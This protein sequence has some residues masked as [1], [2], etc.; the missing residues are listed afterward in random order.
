MN[1]LPCT[2]M[3][4]DLPT[5]LSSN[6]LAFLEP[7]EEVWPGKSGRK[8][9]LLECHSQ[10]QDS[11]APYDGICGFSAGMDSFPG[12]LFR[13]PLRNVPSKLSDNCYTIEN[14]RVLTSALKSDAKFLL[15]FLQSVDRI[16]VHEIQQ[17]G[18]HEQVFCVG[19][20]ESD[21]ERVHQQRR[22]FITK[23]K[24]AHKRQPYKISQQE[25]LELDFHVQ[26]TTGPQS[27]SSIS[28][29]LVTNLIDCTMEDVHAAA[30][31]L[32]KIPWVGVAMELT[33][34][35]CHE[36]GRIFCF[37]P[38]PTDASSH[39]PVHLNGTFGLN[40]NRRTLKWSGS[41]AQND[42][43]A[44]WNELLLK[45]LIPVCYEKLLSLAK[46]HLK[47][48][49]DQ[50]YQT[51]P[52]VE[53]IKHTP[54]NK[55]LCPLLQSL[56]Q[57][58]NLWVGPP[59]Q[60]WVT[61]DEAIFIPECD[62]KFPQVVERVLSNCWVKL[63]KIPHTIWKAL[64]HL[65]HAV[66]MVTP[67]Y[68]RQAIR[69][70]FN[71]Y[72]HL[73]FEEKHHLLAYC[74]SDNSYS[75]L[76][77]LALLPMAN[78]EFGYF[79]LQSETYVPAYICSPDI[80][81]KLLPNLEHLLV[82]LSEQNPRLHEALQYVAASNLT[83][84]QQI[85]VS[86]VAQQLPSCMPEDWR[87]EQVVTPSP[88]LYPLEWF[89]TFWE[90]VRRYNHNLR[91]FAGQLVVPI[92]KEAEEEGFN[93]TRLSRDSA[94]VYL[95]VNC[96][97]D[98]LQ[99]LTK[100]RLKVAVQNNFPYLY[101][102]Q[103]FLY[104]HKFTAD[105]VLSA[106]ACAYQGRLHQ[107]QN[108]SLTADEA[109][110]LQSFLAN[111]LYSLNLEQREV[112]CNL[113]IF[114]AME[115]DQ[116]YSVEQA[117]KQSWGGSAILEP[118]GFYIGKN[119]LPS[120]LIILSQ[121]NRT[122]LLS[123][124]QKVET[125]NIL[126][127][128]L[129]ILFPMVSSGG[130]PDTQI[131]SLMVEVLKCVPV[132]K[133]QFQ[134][135]QSD[136]INSIGSLSFIKTSNGS[137]KAPNELF[138]PSS[139]ELKDLYKNEPVFPVAPFDDI[140]YHYC[141]RECG[142]QSSV[143]VQQVI[144]II[145][146]IC[147][148]KA[149]APTLVNHTKFTRAKAVLKYL[150]SCESQFFNEEVTLSTR[151]WY[152]YLMGQA[153]SILATN[154]NW[155]PVC[156][157][158]PD[159]YPPCLVWKG[160]TCTCHL[161]SLTSE[162]LLPTHDDADTLPS[163]T[164]SQMYIVDCSLSST[165][166][167]HLM[168]DSFPTSPSEIAKYVWRHF[169]LVIQ[170][171]E[172]ICH[173]SLE[174][175]VHHIYEYLEE[176]GNG[177]YELYSAEWIWISKYHMFVCPEIC[178]L[179][180]NPTFEQNLEPYLFVIP[181]RLQQDYSS[182]FRRYG[183]VEEMSQSQIVS[184]LHMI[185]DRKRTE[186]GGNKVMNMV[187]NI[188]KWLTDD[189]KRQPQLKDED[190]IFVPT[191]LILD[192]PELVQPTEAVYTDNV[193]LQEVLESSEL[194][195]KFTFINQGIS[196]D[197]AHM[198]GV[199]P[200]STQLE[201]S[202]DTFEDVGQ[203][204]P[205]IIRLKNILTDYRDGVT[206]IKELL[207]NA[208]DAEA[209]ELNICYDAR[210]H[211]VPPK[212][213]LYPGMLQC[214][215]P[216]LVVHNDA[217]F[218]RD[219]FTNITKLAGE[220]KMDKPLKI[221][222]FGV[223]FCSVYHITDIPSFV[224][225]EMLYIFDPTMSHLGNSIKDPARPGKKIMFTDGIVASSRQLEPFE[226]LYG[227]DK[228]KPYKGTIFRLPFRTL[229][230]EI[231]SIMYN[232]SMA[233]QLQTNI[234][235]SSS[236]LLVF[237]RNVKKITFSQINP[238]EAFP[239]TLFEVRKK[240]TTL[241]INPPVS[242]NTFN[243]S[244]STSQTS[245]EHLLVASYVDEDADWSIQKYA[246]ASVA[247]L[248]EPVP[249]PSTPSYPEN[250]SYIPKPVTGEVFCFLPLAVH[251]G[252]PVH[253]SSNFAV[254]KSRR[255][256]HASNDPS[257]TLAQFNI[258]LMEHVIPKA[259]CSLLETIQCMCNKG[260][261]PIESYEFFSLWPLKE[262]LMTH[263]PWE[264]L[265]TSL[266]KLISSRE[267]LFSK[268]TKEWV[269]LAESVIL[270]PGILCTSS[271]EPS[272]DCV[273]NVLQI[274]HCQFVDL[275]PDYCRQLPKVDFDDSTMDKHSFVKLFFQNIS[276]LS[277]EDH[278]HVRNNVLMN[279]LQIFS[280]VS[281]QGSSHQ[282]EYLE[283]FL[284]NNRCVPCTPDGADLKNCKDIVNP[285]ASFARLY[286]PDDG[287][288][289]IDNF[290]TNKLISSALTQ[291]GM[292]Q[293]HM[294]WD[295]LVERAKTVQ[296][297]YQFKQSKA[298][299]RTK[300]IIECIDRNHQIGLKSTVDCKSLASIP[301]LP[302]MKRPED[303]PLHWKG[304]SDKLLSGN[305]LLCNSESNVR[306]AGSQLPIV[307]DNSP[308]HSGCGTIQSCV[309][310]V[311][312]ITTTPSCPVV[313]EQLCQ[314]VE[315]S[316]R[317]Q[318]D[319][320]WIETICSEVYKY[321]DEGLKEGT[322]SVC[323][324]H[325]LTSR[326][327]VWTG[328]CFITP[329][330]VAREWSHKGPYLF[331]IPDAIRYK[332]K[333]TDVLGIREEFVLEDFTS[334]LERMHKDFGDKPVT[335]NCLQT[336]LVII[337]KLCEFDLPDQFACFLPDD[338]SVM[339]KSSELAFNDAPWCQVEE[340]WRLVDNRIPRDPAIKLGVK[341]VRS[342]LLEQ[343]ESS[344]DTFGSVEFGQREPL[345]QRIKNILTQY[346][347][348]QTV[349][350]ELLQN[351]DDAKATK[352]YVILDKRTHGKER[353]PKKKWKDLQGPALVVWNDMVFKEEDI[354]GIQQLGLGSKRSD[355]ESI[356]QYGI[357]F[358]VVYNLTDCPSFIT[359]C[360]GETLCVFDPHC[361]YIP[362]ATELKPGR[363]YN[364]LNERFW[365]TYSDLK[366][367]YLK[368]NISNCPPEM[369]GGTL[370]RFPLRSTPKLVKKSKLV[371]EE[372]SKSS[373][374]NNPRMPMSSWRMQENV[375]KWVTEV[376]QALFFLNNVTEIRFFVIEEHSSN[377]TLMNWY[378]VLL[379]AEA[380]TI[381]AT[382]HDKV[383]SFAKTEKVPDV[384]CYPLTLLERIPGMHGQLS[385]KGE[386]WLIQQGVGDHLNPEQ[387]WKFTPQVKPKHGIA[388][389]LQLP[390]GNIQNFRGSVFC[391]LPLPIPSRLPI[392]VNGNFILDPSRRDLWHST[393][394]DD[395]DDRTKWNRR[396]VE[397]IAS[398]YVKFLADAQHYYIDPKY[399]YEKL[400]VL[401]Q[402]IYLYYGA[403]PTWLPTEKQS[404]LPPEGMFLLLAKAVYK[405]LKKQN[406]TVMVTV[407][408]VPVS[409]PS[410]ITNPR[411]QR[412]SRIY[413]SVE[414]HPLHNKSKPSKQIYFFD[415]TDKTN[416]TNKEL[417]PILESIG[418][419]LTRTPPVI[420]KHFL[421]LDIELPEVTR[422]SVFQYYS[423]FHQQVSET[424]DFPYQISDTAFKLVDHFQMFTQY[425]LHKS[426]DI[427][428]HGYTEFPKEPFGLPLLLTADKQLRTFDKD[429]MVI[430]STH[431]KIF[432][433]SRDKFLH[434][435]MLKLKYVSKYFICASDT[436]W[437]MIE[438]M[439]R[440]EIPSTLEAGSATSHHLAFLRPLW[441]CLSED[442]VFEHHLGE[443]LE[444]WALLLSTNKQLFYFRS[445]EQLLPVIAPQPCDDKEELSSVEELHLQVFKVLQQ[446]GVPVLD[447]DIV[448]C[449][450]ASS[451]CP[452][453]QYHQRILTSLY[454]HYYTKEESL[455]MLLSNSSS[456]E[457]IKI[458]FEYFKNIHFAQE[459]DSLSK[460][461]CLPFFK[462]VSGELHTLEKETY[463]WPSCICNAKCNRWLS[464]AGA[465]FLEEHGAWTTLASAEAL[466]IETISV[467]RVY[468]EFIFPNFDHL[469]VEER[470]QQLQHVRDQLFDDADHDKKSKDCNR[471]SDAIDF[472][473]GLET[474]PCLPL[475]SGELRPVRDFCDPEVPLFTTFHKFFN[476]P[477][478]SMCSSI[479]LEFLRKIGLCQKVE[480]EQF[481]KFCW[482]VYNGDHCDLKKASETLLKYLM[483]A[484]EWYSDKL[485]LAEVSG[486]P[487]VC[488][489][490]L[491]S[492][493]WIK[494]M[495]TAQKRIQQGENVVDLTC[496]KGAALYRFGTL[497]WTVKP[498]VE[499]PGFAPDTQWTTKADVLEHIEIIT[500]PNPCD[501]VRNV[502]NI[503]T[504]RFSNF[505]LFDKYT[506]DC[507]QKELESGE[508]CLLLN[509]LEDNFRFLLE[510]ASNYSATILHP[511]KD[512]PCIPVCAEGKTSDITKPVLVHPLQVI[513]EQKECKAA[514]PFINPLPDV[515]FPFLRGVLSGVGV[516]STLQ[517]INVQKALETIHKYVKQPLDP[518][519]NKVVQYL[520]KQLFLLLKDISDKEKLADTLFPLFLPNSD[521]R[522]VKSTHLICNDMRQYRKTPLDFSGLSYSLFSLLSTD[523]LSELG[524]SP[525]QL[526][527]CLPLAVS[528]NLLS[529]CCEEELH[530]SCT[531][532]IKSTYTS[533]K[534]HCVFKLHMYIARAAQL[535]IQHRVYTCAKQD[536]S[537]FTT[538]LQMFLQN[539]KI[540]VYKHL[541]AD[542]FLT[543]GTSRKKIG[544]A[545]VPYLIQK[546]EQ[547]T[548]C[549]CLNE[550]TPL[551]LLR[552]LASSMVSCVAELCGVDPKALG[553]PEEV[554]ANLLAVECPY[555][556]ASILEES[557]IPPQFLQL[558]DVEIPLSSQTL[559][560]G[561][562]VPF[563][564]HHLLDQDINNIFRPEELVGYEEHTDYIIFAR[565][566]YCIQKDIEE[567]EEKEEGFA[568]YLICTHEDDESGKI[569]SVLDLYK[570]ARTESIPVVDCF[571]VAIAEHSDA[572]QLSKTLHDE[573]SDWK[574]IRKE[575][576]TALQRI[577]RLPEEERR[578][579]IKRLYLKWH[580]DKNDHKLATEAFQFLKQQIS[581]LDA[582][583]PLS[584]ENE[585][586]DHQI[587]SFWE[588]CWNKWNDIAARHSRSRQRARDGGGGGGIS[589][590]LR[591][592]MT[593]QQDIPTAR[594]WLQQ[595]EVDM[596]VLNTV[597]MNVDASPDHAGH[598]CFL[599]HEVAEKA[600][601]AGKYATCGLHPGDLQHHGLV[602]HARALEQL[603]QVK[604]HLTSGLSTNALALDNYYL[605]PRFPNQ[606]S[607]P[608]VPADH[609]T[610]DQ[611][612]NAHRNVDR[613]LQMMRN[614]V[615]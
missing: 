583:L 407:T 453:F 45:H 48:S 124:M 38:L 400:E 213:L 223:G 373:A 24:L 152:I 46:Q 192:C 590:S 298:L 310:N 465:V 255:G 165:V 456:N 370:F 535:I 377:L 267:L 403:F 419:Q 404:H 93:V 129:N 468:T 579:G 354:Q 578:K 83:H 47:V 237:L 495:Q 396:L 586:V 76:E 536:C 355:E 527:N 386:K 292:I 218:T 447:T 252:L 575:I 130:Y 379:S 427:Q 509:V 548:F 107:I 253:V 22:D 441:L 430:C 556:I 72:K 235:Q 580:P 452:T 145:E 236:K 599:A 62:P 261:V 519:T 69:G 500:T 258:G 576:C 33:E 114:T 115:G 178:S 73:T 307:G 406:E 378:K 428:Y 606:Y 64:L 89:R 412:S 146:S 528:P 150:S 225:Q 149:E 426:R 596:K 510:R 363:R 588:P 486:I 102:Q 43:A 411:S 7:H 171:Q 376:K 485:F 256:I 546:S 199:T 492:L 264:Q 457:N 490:H 177:L 13:F 14:L 454:Y 63:V 592:E 259:Y 167:E 262:M 162:V 106:M 289:P 488:A 515:L 284:R 189:G 415:N 170:Q 552:F 350:K 5:I 224:S 168:T 451:Y 318:I 286:D 554:I 568:H 550:I 608:A 216:A 272:L 362:G 391:F 382:F 498:I 184:V 153:I 438:R 97:S 58:N 484:S 611:A 582:G 480:K 84:L 494:H 409:D 461:K 455:T 287:V 147:V 231:S 360:D 610:S 413:F 359:D 600:L 185:K 32:H 491:P 387:E 206:I 585:S 313:I 306:L 311:L 450:T 595:A 540:V 65:D 28:H 56:F 565:V 330:V 429:N 10:H 275:P 442:S 329:G 319:I 399:L 169:Q 265:I 291:L 512:V 103:L 371:D 120:K 280:L 285:T 293:D 81:C 388:A 402:K 27:T 179:K 559:K 522:L 3:H 553:N 240:S 229:Q 77:S 507:K 384:V 383:K 514:H 394:E 571:E 163:I 131:D 172:H 125:P 344:S 398:S 392:H 508:N 270:E 304:E 478:Q 395:P 222:K 226:A 531:E 112:L 66:R 238:G 154:S 521:V 12:T 74:L 331:S 364:K 431:Y 1:Y 4:T 23:L 67:G 82:D 208:D 37:L 144:L 17:N 549:L 191:Q 137:R 2:Y 133:S 121:S 96:H 181:E 347:C 323:D 609:F 87:N 122:S 352:M 558:E 290:Y 25:L 425:L 8:F 212:S 475:S 356:G 91:N 538:T 207:Q 113:P 333:L 460:I 471:K 211:N 417:M 477:P 29:W 294:P 42:L 569:V 138:D 380:H 543:L 414:W 155:L 545:E 41:E 434:P 432:P 85:T 529:R 315:V 345:T 57:G 239:K 157:K 504:S 92:S 594:V 542:I 605:K 314:L 613:I 591:S 584:E 109:C 88:S 160:S 296:E 410:S 423:K 210:S 111:S 517:P 104:L 283:E 71:S 464:K 506:D 248:L 437:P 197:V 94:V 483:K 180:E 40:S 436:N 321:L 317:E 534:L 603:E 369:K 487:F 539:T 139:A 257:D 279:I 572:T 533:E 366:T 573:D 416:K 301:F 254:M 190:T 269:T 587:P 230:S 547:Q 140:E 142:L 337:S 227:F 466:G 511:L 34:H 118:T 19:I 18:S 175:I 271:N 246:T 499:L 300:L 20:H 343:Y 9:T 445:W 135:Q 11:L 116:L 186:V 15:L 604:P 390:E 49:V 156:P 70:N 174:M 303:Y 161:A 219:D 21:R 489:E 401:L 79:W 397:A 182:L 176:H 574:K 201:I 233:K 581:R 502:K 297:V 51:W 335:D 276:Q 61:S 108:V 448:P 612:R 55:L 381:R 479:G 305:E 52:D 339:C 526:C 281:S 54:W 128:I 78:G 537:K 325:S 463:I 589:A 602:G 98:L 439:L 607:P 375:K 459:F 288:F 278:K 204:E 570:F 119:C 214:H 220:T 309:M 470:I 99:A 424:G 60:Q 68:T 336:I 348:D 357:G 497:L 250:C 249:A 557:D 151:E 205:L 469:T 328:E 221:G 110:R 299:Y 541:Q 36:N 30:C 367:T 53:T 341:P 241:S 555:D 39:L 482:K 187:L 418:V 127:F 183:V 577:W 408:Q 340:D 50:F 422:E 266:Y 353:V 243:F 516:E 198:L 194:V 435:A 324:L 308:D 44:H 105:G 530:T 474:L 202:E 195:G 393:N 598:V 217:S 615:K 476:F 551:N 338:K 134:Y 501:V 80:P 496:L 560:L 173:G 361:R 282:Q 136:L 316:A 467:L 462:D 6:I 593:P 203:H 420:R 374:Y 368:E 322:I 505:A 277:K 532:I 100:L 513:A 614:V 562:L 274:L 472:I 126:Q 334:A 449:E 567:D 597:L 200:L 148:M 188:L 358:N 349:L 75:E 132:L 433:Q 31:E 446:A 16:E 421:S 101:H 520:L 458:L 193:F 493:N 372:N 215:G 601:K 563:E 90:W 158:P 247:C 59:L 327:C 389:P 232:E 166:Y 544:T 320:T 268:S 260:I 143:S 351:A 95:S 342:K 312:N 405:K 481:K 164:G 234:Q 244:I 564:M 26:V 141:L 209:T 159:T 228:R 524:F 525:Q 444:T 503:S 117:A 365:S 518:N 523:P 245:Q 295:M 326:S 263:N 566:V 251:S 35:P 473:I 443:I 123:G 385:K 332:S 196:A 242:I 273:T 302:V 561:D 86:T 440:A 346:P